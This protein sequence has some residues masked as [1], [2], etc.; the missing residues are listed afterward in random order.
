MALFFSGYVKIEIACNWFRMNNEDMHMLRLMGEIDRDGSSSQRE[1]SRRLN[2]SLGLVNTFIKK[3]INK[4]YFTVTTI[5]K[6]RL[7]YDLTPEG[8]AK[9]GILTVEYLRYS[10]HFYK[11]IKRLLVRRFDEM[12]KSSIH[13]VIFL[14]AGETAELAYLYMLLSGVK[15]VG[16]IDETRFGK[17]FFEHRI[18]GTERLA[19]NDWDAV[20][21]MRLN[22]METDTQ[23]LMDNGV[24]IDRIA[25]L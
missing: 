4:G 22:N 25:T 5:S 19:I 23:Y 15:L 1:L 21:L 9:K 20:L 11:E 3:L 6:N 24:H 8:V 16:V 17:N 14:G 2:L 7:Q 18:E 10:S 12:K 13:S